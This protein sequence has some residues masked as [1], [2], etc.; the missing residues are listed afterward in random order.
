[1]PS[2]TP[3]SFPRRLA[4]RSVIGPFPGWVLGSG[5]S[6][7]LTTRLRKKAWGFLRSPFEIEWLEGLRLTLYPGNEICRSIF[8]TGR[9]EPNEFCWLARVLKPGM[10][11]LD[12][13]A[14]LGLYT[15]FAAR[16]VSTTGR[17]VAIE[18]SRR[19]M[20]L[21][22]RN[23]EQNVLSN[24]SLQSLALSDQSAEVELLV[25]AASHA[26]H[27]TLGAFGYNTRLEHREKVTACRLDDLVESAKLER[28]DIIKMD[29]EGAELAAV[30]GASAALARYRPTLLM[31][32]SDRALNHQG[33]TSGE[34]LT[35][36]GTY[37]YDV[38][39]FDPG[40][41]F[42]VPLAPRNYF[43]SENI[44]AVPRGVG[45]R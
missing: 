32:L 39:H 22:R 37:E 9:Y 27:N 12:V 45:S 34:V 35:L 30:R 3:V 15:L 17:V 23:V 25:A 13:G 11:L 40:S 26:G 1:M 43:D 8:V 5:Q 18:P 20:D 21:L 38:F 10:T 24:V 7:D 31:E 41:G 33:A 42:P 28:L 6:A 36:L 14:N 2:A 19:E 29:I 4:A 44:I 16:R